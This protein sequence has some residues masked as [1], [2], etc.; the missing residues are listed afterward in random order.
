MRGKNSLPPVLTGTIPRRCLIADATRLRDVED[1]HTCSKFHHVAYFVNCK[2]LRR[3]HAS[4]TRAMN[5][6]PGGISGH[7]PRVCGTL[8]AKTSCAASQ[9]RRLRPRAGRRQVS[10]RQRALSGGRCQTRALRS[11][12][13][14]RTGL[15]AGRTSGQMRATGG[16]KPDGRD[17]CADCSRGDGEASSTGLRGT[18]TESA[19]EP[20]DCQPLGLAL[21][22]CLLRFAMAGPEELLD[23]ATN[24][25]FQRDQKSVKPGGTAARRSYS[26]VLRFGGRHAWLKVSPLIASDFNSPH[27]AALTSAKR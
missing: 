21:E 19:S 5:A 15:L 6:G 3:N 24:L 27:S 1:F 8:T 12:R 9:A 13:R 18:P 7:W 4:T 10:E 26:R 16:L 20:V 25:Y 23:R 14:C 22:H 11:E 2:V 17:G